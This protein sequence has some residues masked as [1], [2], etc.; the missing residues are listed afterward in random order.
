[1]YVRKRNNKKLSNELKISD[2][3]KKKAFITKKII[4]D[5]VAGL[6]IVGSLLAPR[7]SQAL[8]VS[9]PVTYFDKVRNNNVLKKEI[10]ITRSTAEAGEKSVFNITASGSGAKYL[11]SL[12]K[13]VIL[14]EGETGKWLSFVIKPQGAKIGNYEI[15]LTILGNGQNSKQAEDSEGEGGNKLQLGV[16]AKIFFLIT[17]QENKDFKI[18]SARVEPLSAAS[19]EGRQKQPTISILV[20]NNG[21]IEENIDAAELNFRRQSDSVFVKQQRIEL[22]ENGKIAAFS[23]SNLFLEPEK[24][25]LKLE[26]GNYVVNIN[27]YAKGKLLYSKKSMAYLVKDAA[28]GSGQNSWLEQVAVWPKLLARKIKN[29]FSF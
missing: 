24:D 16:A 8:G 29:W 6:F 14:E 10:R 1:M 13:Q 2:V 23:R 5:G 21:N 27:L 28:K 7:I 15:L 3:M 17:E 11:E 26:D 20:A 9:P 12:S 18:I 4:I 19:K 25:G 22:K